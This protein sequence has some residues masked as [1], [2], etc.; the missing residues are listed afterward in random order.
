MARWFRG[1]STAGQTWTEARSEI[2]EAVAYLGRFYG[3][4]E[5]TI[6]WSR[7]LYVAAPQTMSW[8]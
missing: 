4:F 3:D 2:D 6:E 8:Y 1:G 7:Y 5:E